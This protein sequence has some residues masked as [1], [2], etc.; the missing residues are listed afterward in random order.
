MS[1]S[2]EEA[3]AAKKRFWERMKKEKEEEEARKANMSEDEK[4]QREIMDSIEN[5]LHKMAKDLF[6]IEEY[7]G[8]Y[9][10]NYYIPET[11]EKWEWLYDR[12]E[13]ALDALA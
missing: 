9:K 7:V 5:K 6:E 13:K 8:N 1:E 2:K 4:K 11:K 12:I 3:E 10:D